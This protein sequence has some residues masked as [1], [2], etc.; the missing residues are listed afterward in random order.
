MTGI[1]P[2]DSEERSGGSITFTGQIGVSG[3]LHRLDGVMS[4][5]GKLTFS[6]QKRLTSADSVAVSCR[7]MLGLLS[8]HKRVVMTHRVSVVDSFE[9]IVNAVRQ[10]EHKWGSNVHESYEGGNGLARVLV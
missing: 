2:K 1:R 3:R 7:A 9:A 5:K 4:L 8:L 6:I 10:L